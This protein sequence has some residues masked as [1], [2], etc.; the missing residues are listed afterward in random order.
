[1]ATV[2]L[3]RFNDGSRAVRKTAGRVPTGRSPKDQTDAEELSAKVAQA[4]GVK[5]PAIVRTGEAQTYAEYIEDGVPGMMMAGWRAGQLADTPQGLR[6]GLLDLLID[7][8]D[9]N[10]GNWLTDDDGNIHAIDHGFAWDGELEGAYGSPFVRRFIGPKNP[11]TPDDMARLRPRLEALRPEFEQMGHV[12]WHDSM[13]G[14]FSWAAE[15][16]EGEGPLLELAFNPHQRRGPDGRWAGSGSSAS[17]PGRSRRGP[18][19]TLSE[20]VKLP[21]QPPVKAA[22]QQAVASRDGKLIALLDTLIDNPDRHTGNWMVDVGGNLHAIDHGLGFR[23]CDGERYN[24][25]SKGPFRYAHFVDEP[26]DDFK[27]NPLTPRDIETLRQRL[28]ALTPVFAAEGRD[29]WLTNLLSRLDILATHAKG[30]ED[31]I[32]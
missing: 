32:A 25:P 7:N 23:Y 29:W 28:K 10:P 24:T 4:V 12:D 3:V 14:L 2:Q 13:M 20:T 8:P 30:T 26:S 1:M 16:T 21:P 22:P 9:R 17:P 15:R 5:T 6:L 31:L 11:L 19:P 27:D 18:R